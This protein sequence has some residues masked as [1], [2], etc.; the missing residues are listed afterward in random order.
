LP[1][2]L[3]PPANPQYLSYDNIG[4]TE[5]YQPATSTT[6]I[7]DADVGKTDTINTNLGKTDNV[8]TL[9]K[10]E[11]VINVQGYDD[12]IASLKTNG[13]VVQ[14]SDKLR[15]V[16][17]TTGYA[18]IDYW[19]N[20]VVNFANTIEDYA[21][22]NTS[23]VI[24]AESSGMYLSKGTHY[25][26]NPDKQS[27]TLLDEAFTVAMQHTDTLTIEYW[28]EGS[29]T[30]T[31]TEKFINGTEKVYLNYNGIDTLLT[32]GVNYTTSESGGAG[33]GYDTITILNE[34]SGN[35][36][37]AEGSSAYTFRIT[38]VKEN[39][40]V[41]NLTETPA[42]DGGSY[43]SE[44]VKLDSVTL[45]KDVDY[46]IDYLSKK[47]TLTDPTK[48]KINPTQ[49]G[50]TTDHSITIQYIDNDE[51]DNDDNT[52][53]E[54]TPGS[55]ISDTVKVKK[56]STTLTRG[57]NGFDII[58]D[59]IVLTGSERLTG[60]GGWNFTISYLET[61]DLNMNGVADDLEINFEETPKDYYPAD[62]SQIGS[63]EFYYN[64]VLK[65]FADNYY[66]VN[67][68]QQ[69]IT[70]DSTKVKGGD[71]IQLKYIRATDIL[72]TGSLTVNATEEFLRNSL[73]V[74]LGGVTVD[75]SKYTINGGDGINT[76]DSITFNDGYLVGDPD[77]TVTL[78]YIRKT[79][80]AGTSSMTVTA[81]DTFLRSSLVVK[82]SGSIVDPSKYTINGGDGINTGDSITFNDG[83][84]VGDPT[85]ITLEYFKETV[86]QFNINY[87]P[88]DYNGDGDRYDSEIITSSDTT[89]GNNGVLTPG[90]DY[91]FTGPKTI[92]LQF[93]PKAGEKFTIKYVRKEGDGISPA[94]NI[95]ELPS[96]PISETLSVKVDRNNDSVFDNDGIDNTVGTADDELLI[97]NTH[98]V[99]DYDNKKITIN[100][101][102]AGG[103][104]VGDPGEIRIS[105]VPEDWDR[106]IDFT[107][108]PAD[109]DADPSLKG[110]EKVYIDSNNDG[111]YDDAGELLVAGTDYN[112]IDDDTI[113][114]TGTGVLK[115]G[116][117][118]DVKL[119]YATDA[120]NIINVSSSLKATYG[121]IIDYTASGKR[122]ERIW[123]DGNENGQFE[124]TELLDEDDSGNDDYDINY[125]TNTITLKNNSRLVGRKQIRIEFIQDEK[126]GN[127]LSENDFQLIAEPLLNS[128]VVKYRSLSSPETWQTLTKN[129]DYVINGNKITLID[130]RQLLGLNDNGTTVADDNIVHRIKIGYTETDRFEFADF[131]ASPDVEGLGGRIGQVLED[132]INVKW[133]G[134][135]ITS[136][137]DTK[138]QLVKT[139]IGEATNYINPNTGQYFKSSTPSYDVYKYE[140]K[141]ID[142]DLLKGDPDDTNG[143]QFEVSYKYDYFDEFL[144]STPV[145]SVIRNLVVTDTLDNEVSE[146]EYSI[147]NE[148]LGQ[149]V[150]G[151]LEQKHYLSIHS[152]DLAD[153]T[154]NPGLQVKV[155]YEYYS[156]ASRNPYTAWLQVGPLASERIQITI[157]AFSVIQ[158]NLHTIDLS[159]VEGAETGIER[160][161]EAMDV[162]SYGRSEVGAQMQRI[163]E[164]YNKLELRYEKYT[165]T[166]TN[167]DG[168]D[169]AN[170]IINYLKNK[171][172]MM[173][174]I[175]LY[176]NDKLNTTYLLN[177]LVFA[178]SNKK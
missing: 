100:E 65:S 66:T 14:E 123:I 117:N 16:T 115:I 56:D 21:G 153:P 90:I 162:V 85:S 119:N 44:I 29:R 139:K 176:K 46:T 91:I 41:F 105:Y 107:S 172:Q 142:S 150:F 12:S 63:E 31:T 17:Q 93:D 128:E 78:S 158:R 103:G 134:V 4:T 143:H 87:E 173:Q 61:E 110:S 94:E 112:F 18:N 174:R 178:S 88:L 147:Y 45:T 170:E 27:I 167:I 39:G 145:D 48:L 35:N 138:W 57:A 54:F 75:P 140:I 55:Y 11:P 144:L 53:F 23:L 20:R 40:N 161:K 111:D 92:E 125:T 3:P 49:I 97:E 109:Y 120:D 151:N 166:Y 164:I 146:G 32:A 9:G 13:N 80:I 82:L 10:T 73:E 60:K 30:I 135:D 121:N 68:D 50:G 25:V 74:K 47:I 160:I 5:I 69:S 43:S 95:F 34:Y 141:I 130:N 133:D 136:D 19:N 108:A 129:V 42:N 159:T 118:L 70:L 127:G 64:G 104:I 152:V 155:S 106:R 165:E 131:D 168:T 83:Y 36:G 114:L 116:Q 7:S 67:A 79:D 22:N 37:L 52:I 122:A 58:G 2:P 101:T 98:F 6:T 1:S 33:T 84:L 157:P 26:V 171:I 59:K 102:V 148:T 149:D 51:E 38:Y 8:I 137:K 175:E 132:T 28:V 77:D 99:V 113:E 154:K 24:K 86:R 169:I 96:K 89:R 76:G 124:D 15:G 177:L 156:E 126:N 62:N 71:T 163:A 72:G 81:N